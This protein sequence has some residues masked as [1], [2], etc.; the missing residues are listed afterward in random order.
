M[1]FSSLFGQ[2]MTPFLT[3]CFSHTRF[4][5]QESN[6]ATMFLSAKSEWVT[7]DE[8]EMVMRATLY[9]MSSAFYGANQCEKEQMTL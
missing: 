4:G 5:T 6:K 1:S 8:V 9:L 3:F 7:S 2:F